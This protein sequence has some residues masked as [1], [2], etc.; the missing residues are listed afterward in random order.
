MQ[1]SV[2]KFI[3]KLLSGIDSHPARLTEKT[4]VEAL[5]H[6]LR[7]RLFDR[8]LLRL[9]PDHDGGYL[10]PDDLGGISACFSPGVARMS[11]FE[12]DCAA[13]GMEVFMADNSVQQPSESHQRFHFICKHLGV[14][15]NDVTMTLD[16]WVS[17]SHPGNNDLL[18]QID[19]EGAEYEVFLAA[20]DFLMGRFRVIVAE[21]HSL[22]QFWNEP[23]FNLA[24]R[25]FEKILQTHHCIHIHPNNYEELSTMNGIGIPKVAEFTFLRKDRF[26]PSGFVEDLPHPLDFDNAGHLQ[27]VLL[28]SIWLAAPT[29]STSLTSQG[30]AIL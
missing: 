12:M 13:L 14:I 1:R 6:S 4:R 21:F 26:T 19:I 7:P 20:S 17:S 10:V 3:S 27:P 30:E 29:T 22:D 16:D 2:H 28:P 24:S 5:I 8:G 9:G 11:R 15:T 18:L 23:F 25:A